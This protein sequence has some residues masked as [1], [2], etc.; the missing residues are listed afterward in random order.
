MARHRASGFTLVE[1]LAVTVIIGV[2]AAVAL[3]RY[4]D[5]QAEALRGEVGGRAAAFTTGVNLVNLKW[6]ARGLG[7]NA[8]NVI[9]SGSANQDPDVNAFGW[10]TDTNGQNTIA[11]SAARCINVWNGV[12]RP[13]PTISA[14]VTGTEA[15]R[16]TASGQNCTYTLRRDPSRVIVYNA[17]T[18]AV[19]ATNP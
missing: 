19:T 1:L 11:G 18:G 8:D 4:L 9:G 7:P 15:W 14:T 16:A 10:P 12:L 5:L 17:L 3:P 13:A 6:R 2:L